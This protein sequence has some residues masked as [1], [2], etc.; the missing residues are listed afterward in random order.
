MKYARLALA[1]A[2][3]CLFL[4]FFFLSIL[5]KNEN[6]NKNGEKRPTISQP[7]VK[8]VTNGELRARSRKGG[9]R[10]CVPKTRPAERA[11]CGAT[12]PPAVLRSPREKPRGSGRGSLN[13]KH[14]TCSFGALKAP[15]STATG[16]AERKSPRKI[17]GRKTS[18]ARKKASALTYLD[19]VAILGLERGGSRWRR[20][21][22][23]LVRHLLGRFAA[24]DGR[25]E[26][27]QRD[28]VSSVQWMRIGSYSG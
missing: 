24:V 4:S 3:K 15:T 6:R 5:A 10:W 20:H 27:P 16:L 28:N 7:P 14:E 22:H 18:I 25:R 19:G 17:K 21:A 2:A 12:H 1:V 13:R 23:A 26:R 8:C 9:D 11:Q